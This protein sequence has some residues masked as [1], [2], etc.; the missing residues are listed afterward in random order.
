[1]AEAHPS[2][3]GG[4]VVRG[5]ATPPDGVNSHT[6]E[7]RHP[8]VFNM[9]LSNLWRMIG[10]FRAM[11]RVSINLM[12]D[13]AVRTDPYYADMTR[14]EY[15]QAMGRHPKYW[16]IRHN[17]Y[18]VALCRLPESFDKYYMGIEASARR[19]HKKAVREG[20]VFRRIAFNEHLDAI[21]EVRQ[22]TDVRQGRLMPQD[23]RSGAITPCKD[24]PSS[25]PLHDYPYF[26]VFREGKM[27][28]YAGC[29]I[30]GEICEVEQIL[31]HADHLSLGPVPLLLIGI[32]AY[33]YQSHPQV[34]FFAYGTYFGAGETLRRFK[35]KFGFVPHRVDWELGDS[36]AQPSS[37]AAAPS[38][39]DTAQEGK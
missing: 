14:R 4:D 36:P 10:E 38:S 17:V 39:G 32:A 7:P 20:C 1:M 23:L 15:A 30:G 19:N 24:P 21:R 16:V 3:A 8:A 2:F 11:P 31:G 27:L 13:A 12:L 37:L 22:S 9:Q 25:S 35:R 34:K 26:G 28:G 5:L 18:G 6:F 29:F 33:L